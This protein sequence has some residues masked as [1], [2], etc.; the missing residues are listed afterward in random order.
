MRQVRGITTMLQNLKKKDPQAD[1][2]SLIAKAFDM[3]IKPILVPADER[4]FQSI[5]VKYQIAMAPDNSDVSHF[6]KAAEGSAWKHYLP[7]E[8]IIE[9]YW[10]YT[11][12]SERTTQPSTDRPAPPLDSA[13]WKHFGT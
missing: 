1:E 12:L 10:K 8:L 4:S 5:L 11:P 3:M 7:A 2:M 6:I 13:Y 9:N